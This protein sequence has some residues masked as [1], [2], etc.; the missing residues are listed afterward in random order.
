MRRD[1]FQA[2]ADPTRRAIITL[3]AAHAMTLG[4]RVVDD[5]DPGGVALCERAKFIRHLLEAREIIGVGVREH[6]PSEMRA[7]GHLPRFALDA[8]QLGELADAIGFPHAP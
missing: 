7:V 5:R 1:V 2:I 3:I 6:L 8:P 4:E